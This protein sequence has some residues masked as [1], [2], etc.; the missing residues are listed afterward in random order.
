MVYDA[1]FSLTRE[2]YTSAVLFYGTDAIPFMTGSDFFAGITRS[3]TSLAAG[4]AGPRSAGCIEG[5][6]AGPRMKME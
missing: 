2:L 1:R 4:A 3:F 5:S 6:T